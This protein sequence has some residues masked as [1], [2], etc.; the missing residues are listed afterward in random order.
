MNE[1]FLAHIKQK[2]TGEWH[3]PHLEEHLHEIGQLAAE[4]V[5]EWER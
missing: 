5:A 1:V 3:I 4:M 2:E